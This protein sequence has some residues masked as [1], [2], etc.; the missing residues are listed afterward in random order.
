[1]KAFLRK[2]LPGLSFI[3]V[4]FILGISFGAV[5]IRT[6]DYSYQETIIT[7][8]NDFI[9]G[10]EGIEYNSS[11]LIAESIKYNLIN[12]TVIWL[13]GLSVILMPLIMLLLFFKGFILGFTVGFLVSEYGF[14]GV[15]IALVTVFPQNIIIIPVYLLASVIAIYFSIRLINYYRGRK[16]IRGEDLFI[17]TIEMGFAALVLLGAS[18]IET[19]LS[20]FLFRVLLRFMF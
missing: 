2:R 9:R 3:I 7:Y 10:F 17:Y 5:A 1:M 16:P 14:K 12:I 19:Y 20:P 13:F 6:L 11:S 8:F 15:I 18:L 4:I